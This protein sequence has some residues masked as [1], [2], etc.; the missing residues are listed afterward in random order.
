MS[1]KFF[2][3]FDSVKIHFKGTSQFQILSY[4]TGRGFLLKGP[5]NLMS[6]L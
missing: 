6:H 3:F 1:V 5:V 4:P 2:F